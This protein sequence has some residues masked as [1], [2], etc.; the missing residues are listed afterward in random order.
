MAALIVIGVIVGYLAVATLMFRA[1][2]R[3]DYEN[4]PNGLASPSFYAGFA[5]AWPI[6]W[7]P[8]V[9]MK[10]IDHED[11]IK[12][13]IMGWATKGLNNDEVEDE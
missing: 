11:E 2:V 1:V 13:A 7:V 3:A 8:Y 4:A 9:Y 6:S 12:D 10:W 5:L